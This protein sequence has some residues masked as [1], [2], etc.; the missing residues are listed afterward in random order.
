[1]DAGAATALGYGL[2][3][4][5]VIEEAGN[6]TGGESGGFNWSALG[7]SIGSLFGGNL[8]GSVGGF[9]GGLIGGNKRNK[10]AAK[11]AKR[12]RQWQEY[13]SNTQYQRAV[14]DLKAAGLNPMLAY[15]QGGAGTPSGAMATV[16]NSVASGVSSAQA[17]GLLGAT[18]DKLKADAEAAR[19][20]GRNQDAQAITQSVLAR[21][22]EADIPVSVGSA[23]E[24]ESR[25]RL[26]E[27]QLGMIDDQIKKLRGEQ[28][29]LAARYARE[30]SEARSKG[31]SLQYLQ[32]LEKQLMEIEL[33]I[34]RL[35]LPRERAMARSWEGSYGQDFRAYLN[36]LVQGGRAA[37][38]FRRSW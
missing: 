28:M 12:Q 18:I 17:G 25:S 29:E 9:V 33:T 38:S 26:Q 19:A 31:F 10:A 6:F 35:Q 1:M 24:L 4:N 36:D 5:D 2:G 37:M 20:S 27:G 14:A 23:R 13:M 8:L 3:S 16:E 34:Q 30:M 15:T 11:E 7:S 21:K 22:T 32:P